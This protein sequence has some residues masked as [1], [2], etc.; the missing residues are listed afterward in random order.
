VVVLARV[1]ET[2]GKATLGLERVYRAPVELPDPIRLAYHGDNV[3]R[4]PG[5]PPFQPL[6]GEMAVFVIER[7]TDYYGELGDPDVFRPAEDYR[8][9][10]PLP[11]EGR[12]ALLQAVE[13]LVRF[14]DSD[15]RARSEAELRGWLDG[16]NPWLIDAA[17]TH[18]ALYGPPDEG[19][20]R[21]LI[22][23]VQANDPNRRELAVRAL[24]LGL[25]RG[26]LG[27]SAEPGGASASDDRELCRRA[28]VQA[29]RTDPDPGVRRIAVRSLGRSGLSGLVPVLE[30]IAE[31][32]EDQNVRYEAETL[33]LRA[34]REPAGSDR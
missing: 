33:L 30:V 8:S 21:G 12:E 31:R 5:E 19:W 14:E 6:E 3:A 24:G 7:W 20:T 15:D 29:A 9:R 17:L 27:D 34:R 1:V 13:Q 16:R 11:A 10:I 18:A 26:R 28:L 25:A 22:E 23:H 2:F 4:K 32:D